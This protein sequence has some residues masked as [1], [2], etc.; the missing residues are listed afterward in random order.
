[1]TVKIEN[2]NTTAEDIIKKMDAPSMN[3][4]QTPAAECT[5]KMNDIPSVN[6]PQTPTFENDGKIGEENKTGNF[7]TSHSDEIDELKK[8]TFEKFNE[9]KNAF[10][11]TEIPKV[12]ANNKNEKNETAVPVN[13]GKN[14]TC[15]EKEND[16]ILMI[17][18]KMDVILSYLPQINDEINKKHNSLN[19][20]VNRMKEF[21]NTEITNL[22][23][24]LK[25]GLKIEILKDIFNIAVPIICDFEMVL[26]KEEAHDNDEKYQKFVVYLKKFLVKVYRS[27]ERLGLEKIEIIEGTTIFDPQIHECSEVINERGN[28]ENFDATPPNGILKVKVNGFKLGE[29][30]FKPSDVIIKGDK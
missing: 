16:E 11:N 21:Y 24:S 28:F 29:Y 15:A 19:N 4:P 18:K 25:T 27:F 5:K 2:E 12:P 22:N 3:A 20:S 23:N 10:K 9:F 13:E 6:K 14:S 7:F 1:M 30:V 17:S 8:E 26:T